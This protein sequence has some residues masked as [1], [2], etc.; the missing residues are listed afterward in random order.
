MF[1]GI[2]KPGAC[3]VGIGHRLEGGKG[4]GCDDDESRAGIE[5]FQRVRDVRPIDV[6][7]K[8][9]PWSVVEG[10]KRPDR[11]QRPE[12][13]AADTD[14]DHIAEGFTGQAC[15]ASLPKI[16]GEAEHAFPHPQDPC[17][18]IP[19]GH[20]DVVVTSAPQCHVERGAAFRD[21]DLLSPEHLFAA[22]FD[23]GGPR[24]G[25]EAGHGPGV[26]FFLG[27]VDKDVVK[28]DR[29]AFEAV[30]VRVEEVTKMKRFQPCSLTMHVVPASADVGH[31]AHSV[32]WQECIATRRQ[33]ARAIDG[34][35]QGIR[36]WYVGARGDKKGMRQRCVF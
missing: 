16:P 31:D 29:Q 13:R 14:I 18:D 17:H 35:M 15:S 9:K 7:N 19:A 5:G 12:V 36:A 22:G 25:E 20:C 34:D 27:V 6:G 8:V 1:R 2:P 21:I 11:H 3:G 30:R 10:G 32:I 33:A 23:T 28:A 24:Q 4:L 26:E